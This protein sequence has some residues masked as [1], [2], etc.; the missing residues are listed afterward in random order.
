MPEFFDDTVAEVDV[1]DFSTGKWSTVTDLG[2]PRGGTAS[3]VLDGKVYVIGG[4][5]DN[6]AWTEVDVLSGNSFRAGPDMPEPRHGTGIVSCNGAIWI[7]GGERVLGA[8]DS[9]KDTFA[10]FD[11]DK[12]PVCTG[13]GNESSASEDNPSPPNDTTSGAVG[14]DSSTSEDVPSPPNDTTSGA[15]GDDSSAPNDTASGAVGTDE[16]NSSPSAG[17]FSAFV[18]E[19]VSVDVFQCLADRHCVENELTY[20]WSYLILIRMAVHRT[21]FSFEQC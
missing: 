13:T 20:H 10:F 19:L 6:R 2:R 14:D 4:E 21:V 18:D 11:G 17:K 7:A 16:A 8:G 1:Y 12:P 5:G 3:A 9:A 15:V